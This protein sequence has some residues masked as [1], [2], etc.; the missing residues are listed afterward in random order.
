MMYNVGDIIKDENRNFTIIDKDYFMQGNRKTWYYR[1]HCNICGYNCEDG[2][3]GGELVRANWYDNS[4]IK[5]G[6][7]CACCTNRIVIPHINSIRATNPELSIYF[8]NHDDDKY[9]LYSNQKVEMQC[10]FCKEV[11]KEMTISSLYRQGFSCPICSPGLSIGEKMMY[12][13]LSQLNIF[14]EKEYTFAKSKKRYDFYIKQYNCIIEI[15]GEQHYIDKYYKDKN[16]TNQ[17]EIDE[18]KREFALENGVNKYIII[19]ARKSNFNYI[20][21]SIV[22]SELS[23]LF[24]LDTIDWMRIKTNTFLNSLIKDV[25]E[26]YD[27]NKPTMIDLENRFKLSE[28]TIRKYIQIGFSLGWCAD[29]VIKYGSITSN[30]LHIKGTYE[31]KYPLLNRDIDCTNNCTPLFYEPEGLYF[32]SIGLASKKLFIPKSTIRY[33]LLRKKGFVPITKLQ[34]NNAYECGAYCIGTPFDEITIND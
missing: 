24:D 25:C 11:K 19:D 2:Y 18:E 22:N 3:R 30:N 26:Y 12:A 4:K 8:V 7:K 10:P 17:K 29:R 27:T 6:Y 31:R 9:T 20:Y 16:H 32:K 21:N 23:T 1:Y 15:H 28:T 34:F 33:K 14:F 13:M 5:K